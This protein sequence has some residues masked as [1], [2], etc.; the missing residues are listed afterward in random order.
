MDFLEV[1]I[2]LFCLVIYLLFMLYFLFW[3]SKMI[4]VL[5]ISCQLK[6]W[7]IKMQNFLS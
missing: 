7:Y 1:L 3:T 6:A 5:P 2:L 4:V